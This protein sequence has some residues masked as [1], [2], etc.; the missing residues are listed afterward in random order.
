MHEI[1]IAQD[2]LNA[3]F[4][5]L[6]SYEYDK[7][8]KIRLK[9]GDFNMLTQESLQ[10]AFDLAAEDTKAKGA[11]LIVEPVPGMEI[12]IQNIEAK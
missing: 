11:E 10:N 9:V 6:E 3:V 5:E 7:V 1:G 2:I 12:E 8:K 4:K